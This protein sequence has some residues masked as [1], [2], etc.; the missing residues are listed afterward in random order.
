MRKST[1]LTVFDIGAPLYGRADPQT[2][3]INN[4]DLLFQSFKSQSCLCCETIT[5]RRFTVNEIRSQSRQISNT[6][7]LFA[8][9]FCVY[10]KTQETLL[11][12]ASYIK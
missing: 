12:K 1:E 4:T 3:N 9:Q 6:K 5:T 2:N 8:N 7:L 11:V 10:L